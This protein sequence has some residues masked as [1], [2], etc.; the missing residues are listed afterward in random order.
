[1]AF[2]KQS[3]QVGLGRMPH[4]NFAYQHGCTLFGK[5]Q[6]G[7]LRHSIM[8]PAPVRMAQR[9][10]CCLHRARPDLRG[11]PLVACA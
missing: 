1:M 7:E 10:L 4:L 11:Q 8:R 9:P 2:G 5:P 6:Q 3:L